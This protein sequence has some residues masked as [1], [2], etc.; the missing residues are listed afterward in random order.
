MGVC[1][2]YAAQSKVLQRILDGSGLKTMV[3]TGTVHRYQG[4]EKH[5]MIMDIPDSH[6]EQRAG[7]FLDAD[8]VDDSGAMLFNVAVSRAKGHLIVF[9]NL[10]YLDQKLPGYAILR[11]I[12]SEM[13]NRGKVVDVRDVL[14]MYPIAEDLRRLGRPFNLSPN[15]EKTGLFNQ[16]DFE[17]VCIADIERAKK[18]I[19]I[20]SGFVT[21]QRVAAYEAVF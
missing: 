18:G 2:P 7:I 6:G 5:V 15:A 14:A 10:A 17:Q 19:A 20:F 12:L 8:H 16:N 21:E 1:T 3:D 9:A 4:D 11:D 13:Q